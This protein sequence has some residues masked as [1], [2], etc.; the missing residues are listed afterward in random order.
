MLSFDVFFDAS[1]DKLFVEQRVEF[2]HPYPNF[3]GI[4]KPKSTRKRFCG[5]NITANIVN[6]LR[7]LKSELKTFST[8]KYL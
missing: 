5:I 4:L 1:L 6:V 8:Y 2:I 3:S 7:N